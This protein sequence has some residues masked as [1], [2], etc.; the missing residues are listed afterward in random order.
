MTGLIGPLLQQSGK[1][2]KNLAGLVCLIYNKPGK[3][4]KLLIFYLVN[5]LVSTYKP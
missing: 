3:P 2:S 4:L 5:W 1:S